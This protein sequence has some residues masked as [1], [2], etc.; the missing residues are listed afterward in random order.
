MGRSEISLEIGNTT[1][2]ENKAISTSPLGLSV[3]R[4]LPAMNNSTMQQQTSAIG[5]A[6]GATDLYGLFLVAN[7]DEMADALPKN[8]YYVSSYNGGGALGVIT[9]VLG[10]T[11]N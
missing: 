9:V 10:A 3:Y 11:A 5:Q 4:Q 6:I 2:I 8:I 7:G 1:S